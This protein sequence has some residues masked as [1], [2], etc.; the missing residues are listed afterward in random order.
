MLLLMIVYPQE[1]TDKLNCTYNLCCPNSSNAEEPGY[2]C[3]G[4]LNGPGQSSHAVGGEVHVN[5]RESFK[6][7]EWPFETH[8]LFPYCD[9]HLSETYGYSFPPQ[10]E[11]NK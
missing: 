3:G 9:I 7:H 2:L 5:A 4:S 10:S 1:V 8:F 6:V 11:K